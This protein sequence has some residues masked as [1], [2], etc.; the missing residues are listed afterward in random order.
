M[1][2]DYFRA[3]KPEPTN[4]IVPG[5]ETIGVGIVKAL[6][7]HKRKDLMNDK[8]VLVE[9]IDVDAIEKLFRPE[10]RESVFDSQCTAVISRLART[11]R[12]VSMWK[13]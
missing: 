2:R 13:V 7:Q 9:I 12:R 4:Y 10:N 6:S 1:G 11:E 8:P 3:V 5:D